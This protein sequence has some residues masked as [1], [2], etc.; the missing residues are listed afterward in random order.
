M[1]I[2]LFKKKLSQKYSVLQFVRVWGVILVLLFLLPVYGSAFQ[3]P[4]TGQ[5]R[6]YD[7]GGELLEC[8]APTHPWYGQDSQYTG[9]RS[10]TKLDENGNALPDEAGNWKAVRDNVTGLVWEMKT[11]DHQTTY[12]WCDPDPETNGGNAGTC[13]SPNTHEFIAYLNT[14]TYGG[15]TDWR[16]PTVKELSTLLDMSKTIAPLINTD[17]FP[18]TVSSVYWSSSTYKTSTGYAWRVGFSNGG[19]NH[20]LKS[21][22][23]YVRAV[24]SGQ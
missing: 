23:Y 17:Y 10:Y 21:L 15:R 9:D 11:T 7:D 22:K 13:D 8:P 20:R 1:E 4:D 16:L 3:W 6:Y 24:S 14:M 5:D 12:Y 2:R 18:M 19:V